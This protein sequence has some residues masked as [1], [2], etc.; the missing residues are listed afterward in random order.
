MFAFETIYAKRLI[1]ETIFVQAQKIRRG[2][3]IHPRD[4]R[5]VKMSKVALVAGD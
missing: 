1:R 4:S 5:A 3:D 2:D